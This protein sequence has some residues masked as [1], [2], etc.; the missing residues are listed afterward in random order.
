M[1]QNKKVSQLDS[2]VVV[3]MTAFLFWWCFSLSSSFADET[4]LW[5][6]GSPHAL[7]YVPFVNDMNIFTARTNKITHRLYTV[8]TEFC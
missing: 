4:Y 6:N 8:S 3:A 5:A 7:R 2:F 1:H